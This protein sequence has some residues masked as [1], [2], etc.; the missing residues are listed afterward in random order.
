MLGNPK[1]WAGKRGKVPANVKDW[2]YSRNT[3]W[4]DNEGRLEVRDTRFGGESGGMCNAWNRAETGTVYIGGGLSK[5]NNS[6][7]KQCILFLEKPPAAAVLE[8][9]ASA[10]V[11]VDG[12][13]W[14]ILRAA[15]VPAGGN[16]FVSG[17]P[18]P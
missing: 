17:V 16:V 8:N 6:L 15:G 12:V 3:R 7:T 5:F 1:L 10:P 14:R 11:R 9:I 2:P 13:S 4:F 18:A